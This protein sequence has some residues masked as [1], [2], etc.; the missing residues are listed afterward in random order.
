MAPKRPKS[1]KNKKAA[2]APEAPNAANA[3]VN[4]NDFDQVVEERRI[5]DVSSA[6][7]MYNRFVQDDEL[8]SRTVAQ[9]RNQLEGG[10]PRDPA[11]MEADGT[12]WQTNVNFGDAQA[13]RDQTLLPFWK[14]IMDVPHK[15]V[16]DIDLKTPRLEKF[17]NAFSE[18]FD[19]FL[20]DWSSGHQIEFM[21]FAKNFVDMGPGIPQWTDPDSPR[22]KSVNVSRIYWPKD[23]Q[24]NQEEW[25]VVALT[26]TMSASEM[27]RKVKDPHSESA[28]WN[29]NALKAA[30]VQSKDGAEA[31]DWRDY[32]KISDQLVNNDIAIS[33]PFQPMEMV[34]LYVKQFS[35]KIGCYV[36]SRQSGVDEFV[37]RDEEYADD[38]KHILGPV[39][40]DTGTDGMIH[41]IKGFGIKNYFFSALLN[42]MKSRYVD[43]GIMS[44]GVNF[45]YNN[46]NVPSES[47]PVEQ[48]GPFTIFPSGITQLAIYPQLQGAGGVIEMLSGNQTQNN[49]IYKQ[50]EKQ[51]EDSD[52][53]TQANIL[54]N[55]QGAMASSSAAIFLS[56]VGDNIFTEQVRRLRKRGNKDKDAVKFVKRMRQRGVPD[57]VIFDADIRVKT[58]ANASNA[59]PAMRAQMFQQDLALMNLPG[60]NGRW[61]LEQLIANKYGAYAVDQ[62][63]LPEGQDSAPEQRRQARM[64]NVMFGQGQ[65]ME[66]VD[67]D[68]HFEHIEEHLNP[69]EGIIGKHQ[70]GQQTPGAQAGQSALT[71][72]EATALALGVEHTGEHMGHLQQDGTMKAQFQQ[73][74]PR[75]R[76]VQS[77]ARGILMQMKQQSQENALQNQQQGASVG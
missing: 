70:Q 25:E 51:I 67:S 15:A 56:Q 34:W 76:M 7:S 59:S 16:F 19:E 65:P 41:S 57:M 48:Y 55:L 33:T 58:G 9:T 30:I 62:A 42:R 18:C 12:S 11:T 31:P 75:F 43:G 29:L 2:P 36:F 14:S 39:W 6:R 23:C 66:V 72:E 26:R 60:V 4:Q 73:V 17:K 44:L 71:P 45:Q 27:Y 38:Y 49:S 35:G 50:Q 10:R 22:W 63:L 68:A 69:L 53:A 5:K 13:Q 40:Y 3:S 52:T 32:T 64:E 20:A 46:D 77:A 28:G 1:A 47:P 37:F 54:A 61:F 24:M 74:A 21:K 8:R